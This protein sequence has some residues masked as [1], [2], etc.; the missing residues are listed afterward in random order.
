M[1]RTEDIQHSI[2]IVSG[3]DKFDALIRR[4]LRPGTFMSVEFRKSAAAARRC[5]LE[6]YFD[7]VVVNAPLPDE[8]GTEFTKDIAGRLTDASVFIIVPSESYGDVLEQV[9]DY[10]IMVAAKPLPEIQVR[11]A[12]RFLCAQQDKIRRLKMKIR[13]MEEKTEE[14]RIVSK[15]KC[16]LV[17]RN[18]MSEDEAHRYIG[19]QAMN[20]GISR[21]RAAEQITEMLEDL[22]R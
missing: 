12:I 9:T 10:G 15:A 7:I 17:A 18:H 13:S 19:R 21:R 14:I 20:Q 5:L 1:P 6:R 11:Y 4:I 22:P 8:Y 16:L 3:A 2:L